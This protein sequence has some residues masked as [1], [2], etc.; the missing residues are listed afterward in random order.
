[1]FTNCLHAEIPFF[2]KVKE[3]AFMVKCHSF[4]H[5]WYLQ[6]NGLCVNIN[7]VKVGNHDKKIFKN[8]FASPQLGASCLCGVYVQTRYD[9]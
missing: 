7:S 8:W 9:V 4:M 1:M 5:G 2:A 3:F 6:S